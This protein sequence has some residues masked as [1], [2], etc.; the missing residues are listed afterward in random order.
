MPVRVKVHGQ[1]WGSGRQRLTEALVTG[2]TRQLLTGRWIP[3]VEQEQ[4]QHIIFQW[5]E[6]VEKNLASNTQDAG[7][8]VGEPDAAKA[9][10]IELVR[11]GVRGKGL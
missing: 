5:Q 7:K 2:W 8:V 1:H 9:A 3:R 11:V 4:G 10:Q 6:L